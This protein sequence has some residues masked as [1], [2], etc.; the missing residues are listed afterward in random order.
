MCK[1]MKNVILVL[2]LVWVSLPCF[3]NNVRL[4]GM[5][6][7]TDVTSGVATL[8]LDL[9]WDNSWRDNFNWDAVWIFLKY[10]P[11][12]SIWMPVYLQK[13]GNMATDGYQV[14]N[15]EHS[16]GNVTGVYVFLDKNEVKQHASTTVTLKWACPANYTKADF[17]KNQVFLLAQGIEMVYIPFGAYYLGDGASDKTLGDAKG[18]PLLIN[19]EESIN[20]YQRSS[21]GGILVSEGNASYPKGYHGFYI[22]KYETSQEQYV[23]FLNTLIKAQQETLLGTSFLSSLSPGR[24]IFGDTLRPS[25]RNGIVLSAKPE[26]QP[27]V[28][29]HDLNGNG[30]YGENGDGQCIACNYMSLND[31]LAYAS[32]AGLRPMSE[33]EYE[34]ACRLPFPQKPVEGEYVWNS[35]T[36]VSRV[37]S[38]TAGGRE[39]EVAGNTTCNV[40]SGNGLSG[41][42]WGP[43]RCGLFARSVST[44]QAA[45]A[46]YW[47]V[48]EMGGNV[49]EIVANIFNTSLVRT[50]NGAG[51][52]ASGLWATACGQYSVRGG[53]FDGADS[54]LRTSDRSRIYSYFSS[55]TSRDSTV[56]FRLVRS[57]DAGLVTVNPGM[58]SLTAPLCPN[59][60]STVLGDE[61][62]IDNASTV[63]S[64][65]YI[66]SYSTDNGNTWTGIPGVTANTLKYSE[67]ESGKTY[68]FR[69]TAVCALGEA[70][71]QS[72]AITAFATTKITA[73]SADTVN[74]SCTLSIA[75]AAE[76]E[77]LTY[78]WQKDGEDIQNAIA[79]VY[80]KSTTPL[81]EDIGEY[82]CKVSGIC[83]VADSKKIYV[84]VGEF[85]DEV[86]TDSR[87]GQV[88]RYKVRRLPD[89]RCW[90]VENLRF[91]TC[92]VST[93]NTYYTNQRSVID[94][95]AS[96]YY[97]VCVA[98]PVAGGGH[99]YNWQAVMNHPEAIPGG[100]LDENLRLN[101]ELQWKGICPTGWHVPSGQGGEFGQLYMAFGNDATKFYP[102]IGAFEGVLG[103]SGVRNSIFS[104][105]SQGNYWSSYGSSSSATV[106][107]IDNS[108]LRFGSGPISNGCA[109]RCV[110]NY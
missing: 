71:V 8:E 21:S 24:Y 99:L 59:V 90:M 84:R 22:M 14:M 80:A 98:S 78:Q 15:G 40:N 105:G 4:N 73:E 55:L 74:V 37:T 17:D 54:L 108:S 35:N 109:V 75:V 26:G 82:I 2:V 66:W 19:G 53:S 81:L 88:E 34:R 69:R 29:D 9:T 23:T 85:N 106:I 97:G 64:F 86:L 60:E 33:L 101:N 45:G 67:F 38:I 18:D 70:S 57:L 13:E 10:K 65:S 1:V 28:F 62:N 50:L 104:G 32:W 63:L 102:G 49:Q 61:A 25:C 48:M 72:T 94:Q 39:T 93:F 100:D 31:M 43:V 52:Y 36:G 76:G 27:Y 83:G 103:G 95:I 89:G 44:Q 30:V 16:D 110:K 7:V 68:L 96:G 79:P 51:Y 107:M 41:D 3:S 56:G 87:A 20:I 92:N 46:T 5:V 12:S 6:K 91:G 42:N 11:A 77:S 58:I 47:G